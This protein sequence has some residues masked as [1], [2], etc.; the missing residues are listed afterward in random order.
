VASPASG[1]LDPSHADAIPTITA[2]LGRLAETST[3][4]AETS[5]RWA[6]AAPDVATQEPRRRL[7]T[8]QWLREH[9]SVRQLG[10]SAITEISATAASPAAAA[11]LSDAALQ[12]VAA[13]VAARRRADIRR[14]GFRGARAARQAGITVAVLPNIERKGKV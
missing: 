9:L 3:V 14:A 13:V 5:R 4:L 12:S 6:A 10:Q 7:A 8:M 1:F 2:N 11:A